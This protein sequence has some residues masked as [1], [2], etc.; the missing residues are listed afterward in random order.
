[1]RRPLVAILF[2]LITLL[3]AAC[4]RNESDRGNS[5]D[6]PPRFPDDQ[7]VVT[8][9]DLESLTIENKR[10]YTI[11][12]E[13]ESFSTYNQ[14]IIPLLRWQGR[15]VHVGT[16]G[17]EVVWIAGI[18]VVDD[19]R[20]IPVV[21]Y[22]NGLLRRID[23]K[24]RAIFADGTVLRLDKPLGRPPLNE[25][26]SMDIDAARHVVIGVVISPPGSESSED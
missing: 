23:N 15:Y 11:S 5:G 26:M 18:G 4:D 2:L 6:K 3:T 17:D 22:T 14:E 7:G 1:M 8:S 21:H 10:S 9:V 20:E 13:V 19:S 12:R 24:K 25:R 16:E